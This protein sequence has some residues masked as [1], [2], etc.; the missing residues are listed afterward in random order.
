MPY[1]PRR[2]FRSRRL[3]PRRRVLPRPSRRVTRPRRSARRVYK[4]RPLGAKWKNPLPQN[5]LYRFKYIDNGFSAPLNGLTAYRYYHRFTGNGPYDPDYTGAGV[6][7][8]GWDEVAATFPGG[9]Y[10]VGGSAITINWAIKGTAGS[11][12]KVFV[13]PSRNATFTYTDVSDLR[14]I[15]MVRWKVTDKTSGL[16]RKNWIKSYCAT[17]SLRRNF[18]DKEASYGALFNTN[19]TSIWFWHVFFDAY[20]MSEDVNIMFDVKIVYYAVVARADSQNES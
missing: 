10:R 14:N 19:P 2:S 8:Y 5:A 16:G 20:D 13:I 15:P 7:P 17:R 6:Q 9:S 4:V 12:I 11:Q 18:S 3:R 1:V